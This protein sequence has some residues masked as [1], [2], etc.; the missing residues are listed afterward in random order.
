MDDRQNNDN[1]TK[2]QERNESSL[3]ELLVKEYLKNGNFDRLIYTPDELKRKQARMAQEELRRE[4]AKSKWIS[5]ALIALF[6]LLVIVLIISAP[7]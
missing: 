1:T 4:Q 5:L 3:E 6:A 2:Y 7:V